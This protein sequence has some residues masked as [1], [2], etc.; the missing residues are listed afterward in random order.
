MSAD[1]DSKLDGQV[2]IVT[3]A[4]SGIGEATA[5]ALASRGASVVLAA[6]RKNELEALADQIESAGGDSL[7][8]P[9][10]ITEED[11]IDALVETT[12][13]EFD[14]IDVLV[15]N[16]G[17]MLLEPVERADRENFRQM[18]EV[19]LLGL[20][21]LTHAALPVMQEQGAG[22]IVNVSSTAGRDANANN[23]GYSATKF[24]VNAFS[25]SLRQEVT[26]EGIR[27]TIIEPGAVETELQE[28]VP[29]EEIKEQIEDGFLDSITPLQS[30]DIADAIAYA[31]T[32]P[33]HISI[34]EMLIRPTDQQL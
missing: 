2:A 34:N 16:A 1:F 25:E 12:L 29:D 10:D 7:P 19:N 3:G 5:T 4:S 22:H 13:E 30:E 9:T 6:R 32:R 17:V 31:V 21:N 27:T 18:V 20:M 11:D 23:S 14:S 8:V 33:Q 26:T 15:N 28:H 24:G